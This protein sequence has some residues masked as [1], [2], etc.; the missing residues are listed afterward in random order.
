MR[1]SIFFKHI[2]EN[3]NNK[4]IPAELCNLGDKLLNHKDRLCE[5]IGK[6]ATHTPGTWSLQNKTGSQYVSALGKEFYLV[7]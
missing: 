2:C 3:C 6:E 4:F 5:I 7:H 1:K